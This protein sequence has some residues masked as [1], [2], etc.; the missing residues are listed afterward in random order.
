LFGGCEIS[1]V[2]NRLWPVISNPFWPCSMSVYSSPACSPGLYFISSIPL[3]LIDNFEVI[4]SF[5]YF[6]IWP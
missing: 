1:A 6:V 3:G 2:I 5:Y 4:I